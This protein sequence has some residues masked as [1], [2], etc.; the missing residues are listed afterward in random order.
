MNLAAKVER[1]EN[2]NLTFKRNK[3]SPLDDEGKDSS[4]ELDV[5]GAFPISPDVNKPPLRGSYSSAQEEFFRTEQQAQVFHTVPKSDHINLKK[6][7]VHAA[8]KFIK[9]LIDFQSQYKIKLNMAWNIDE[10]IAHLIARINF[11]DLNKFRSLDN[12]ECEKLIR[13]AVQPQSSADFL[14]TLKTV[15]LRM[16]TDQR[17]SHL[18]FEKLYRSYLVYSSRFKE[19]Y[20][21]MMNGQDPSLIPPIEKKNNGLVL[22]FLQGL[23]K[24]FADIFYNIL[25]KRKYF[26]KNP[27]KDF[28]NFISYFE[29]MVKLYGYDHYVKY[30]SLEI[31]LTN[32]SDDMDSLRNS[33]RLDGENLN[34]LTS[35]VVKS[36]QKP[37]IYDKAKIDTKGPCYKYFI[38]KKCEDFSKG[39]CPYD[40][41]EFTMKSMA[42]KVKESFLSLHHLENKVNE[43]V[44]VNSVND[45]LDDDYDSDN[46]NDIDISNI[47]NEMINED[48][49]IASD[50]ETF[51]MIFDSVVSSLG[52]SS[53]RSPIIS[54]EVILKDESVCIRRALLD[55]GAM[56]RNYI[57]HSLVRKL[58]RLS[59]YELLIED[60]QAGVIL[61]D[62]KTKVKI[63]KKIV[64]KISFTDSV[65]KLYTAHLEFLVFDTGYD[66]IIGLQDI[67]EHFLPLLVDALGGRHLIQYGKFSVLEDREAD[68]Q[69][70]FTTST[71][72]APEE[73]ATEEPCSFPYALDY[74]DRSLEEVR[75]E[76]LDMFDSQIS[77][78][79]RNHPGLINLL[80]TKGFKVFCPTNWEGIKGVPDL[81]LDFNVAAPKVLRPKARPIPPKLYPN[82]LSEFERLR[83]YF[84]RPSTSQVASCLVIAPKA[85]KPFI[86][87]CGDYVTIN[88]FINR[89]TGYIP[90]I[91]E[92]LSKIK[93]FKFFI[94]LDMT[95]S[96]HQIRIGPKTSSMLSITTPWGQFEPIFLPEGVPPASIILQD[97]VRGLFSELEDRLVFVFDNILILG[98]DPDDCLSVLD[99]VFTI[100]IE[101]NVYLKF[102]KSFF[103]VREVNFFGYTC[104][105]NAWKLK[106][107]KFE[108][109]RNLPLPLNIKQLRS[110]L[111]TCVFFQRFVPNFAALA[112]PFYNATKKD[113]SWPIEDIVPYE[114]SFK[115]IKDALLNAF[116]LYF[117]DYTLEWIL[118]TDASDYAYGA[119]LMQLKT[120]KDGSILFQPIAFCSEKFSPSATKWET[121]KKEAYAIYASVKKWSY[122]LIG[123]FFIIE[124]DHNN[125]KWMEASINPMIT[126]WRIFLQ[127]YNCMIRHIPG[128]SNNVADYMSR[129]DMVNRLL[130]ISDIPARALPEFN[131]LGD[132]KYHLENFGL[133]SA[134]IVAS[135]HLLLLGDASP[136]TPDDPL[137]S[138]LKEV[139]NSSC[140]HFGPAKTL[141]I[142]NKYL[143]GH[144]IPFRYIQEFVASC[145]ICQKERKNL[146]D[147]LVGIYKTIKQP[148][149][150]SAIGV[151]NVTIS[152]KDIHGNK[153]AVV[154]INL[155]TRLTQVYPHDFPS[156]IN[157]ST[158][159]LRFMST[160]GLVRY[161]YSDP[162]SDLTSN[163][164]KDLNTWL[165][166]QHR[167][168]LVDRHESNGAERVIFEVTKHLRALCC[169]RNVYEKW[170]DNSVL[171]VI[172]FLINSTYNRES[173]SVSQAFS[174]F[175]LTFGSLN[176]DYFKF[177]N[178]DSDK[179][180]TQ[181]MKDLNENFKTL[182][183]ASL[184][185]QM[186]I[187]ERR[188]RK[189]GPNN[190]QIKDLVLK[191]TQTPFRESKLSF[192]YKGPYEVT[193]IKDNDIGIRHLAKE[194]ITFTH[195]ERLK[196]FTGTRQ[197][198][199]DLALQD[200]GQHWLDI[201]ATYKG[202]SDV[203]T[204]I[205]LYVVFDDGDKVW[206]PVTKDLTDTAQFEDFCKLNPELSYLLYSGNLLASFKK[207]IREGKEPE[208]YSYKEGYTKLKFFGYD[209]FSGLNLPIERFNIQAKGSSIPVPKDYVMEYVV[210]KVLGKGK[211]E[212]TIPVL[213]DYVFTGDRYWFYA[214]G[215]VDIHPD[216][217]LLVSPRLVGQFP[218][219]LDN[220]PKKKKR[221][222]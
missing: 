207:T 89:H 67:L 191:D 172:E 52:D 85:T 112:I 168:S 6:L 203:K 49:Y 143:P 166:S 17:V 26:E 21:F 220:F 156:A 40:H 58:Q 171:P 153:G 146:N 23:P 80:E 87:F 178:H 24:T 83:K 62:N 210:T 189:N 205:K 116:T 160:Y 218:A 135:A 109:I 93:G 113:F 12:I 78:E 64:L 84:L 149:C 219:I 198:A 211:Y 91:P 74:L 94:D 150:R 118:R 56:H 86:R 144:K 125:L 169:E 45:S 139:H 176:P 200:A 36:P 174:P 148:D 9:D 158:A 101:K 142:L 65:S 185:Y 41:S 197:E 48:N 31:I 141:S 170:S 79:F 71:L 129:L 50:S 133:S 152:P 173:G 96:F 32:L 154:V 88:A 57:S 2:S 103:L 97:V 208:V 7:D 37:Y 29:S 44:V 13:I 214:F 28:S 117:P 11:M 155:F 165:G 81:E 132:D 136:P 196:I 1:M 73:T 92:E 222:V 124:T 54:G 14:Q 161:I 77:P 99:K 47:N 181:Y 16:P 164:V 70:P 30:K 147:H 22:I 209:W 110:F 53:P 157:T 27:E 180:K 215:N 102:S 68:L 122:Y 69:L 145:A 184:K 213:N 138:I 163:I 19:L 190:L 167:F 134:Q 204:S 162:G 107:D 15:K 35:P 216:V 106:E 177:A 100:C 201:I 43:S 175:A 82:A 18:S 8:Y 217:H 3:A 221:V 98:K 127:G 115:K 33:K 130:Y 111:G 114:D 188:A 76:Y 4:F 121:I 25:L 60:T 46:I 61:G 187:A 128:S 140:G 119:V 192:I 20:E 186:E 105:E 212:I 55:T 5:S 75:K 193:S 206:L 59:S 72:E 66:V 51:H 179:F 159:V 131:L 202:D 183:A 90:K 34:A 95:N 42:R 120:D 199:E 38:N 63:D 123:K 10:T 108:A 104:S 151:D 195:I 39:K 194:D 126:R 137:R 182:H